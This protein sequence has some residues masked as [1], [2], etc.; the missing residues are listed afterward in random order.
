MRF[1]LYIKKEDEYKFYGMGEYKY[2]Q[3]LLYDYVQLNGLYDNSKIEFK[4]EKY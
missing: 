2:I 4:I 1:K 3:E